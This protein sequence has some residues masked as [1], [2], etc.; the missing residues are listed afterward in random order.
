MV[1]G[2]APRPQAVGARPLPASALSAGQGEQ[3]DRVEWGGLQ[4]LEGTCV[5]YLPTTPRKVT[6]LERATL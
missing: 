4:S 2:P 6:L 5:T 3:P 1:G